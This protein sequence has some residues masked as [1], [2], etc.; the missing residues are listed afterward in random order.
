MKKILYLMIFILTTCVFINKAN[1][2]FDLNFKQNEEVRDA[3]K[4]EDVKAVVSLN[5]TN[6]KRYIE[7]KLGD[8]EESVISKIGNPSR[9]DISEYDFTWYVYNNVKSNFVMVGIKNQKVVALYSNSIDSSDMNGIKLGDSI[10]VTREN[11]KSIEYKKKGNTKFMI[12]S[13]DQFDIFIEDNKYITVFYDLYNESKVTSYQI[14]DKY[15]EESS[16]DIYP[17]YSKELKD[18]FEK[19]TIDLINSVRDREN[20]NRLSFNSKASVSALKH[21]EDMRDENYFDH[22]NKK[23]E[24]PFNRMKKEHI[25]YSLAGENIAAGQINAIYAHEALMN[26][27]GHRKNILGDYKNIGVGV[28]FGGHYKLYYT[29]NFFSE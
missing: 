5:D 4:N 2:N 15:I 21:S 14:I 1:I 26:S 11:H 22:E 19:Q 7:I 13:R 9:K 10:D 28:S 27:I 23:G 12:D 16:K 20:L 25:R 6:I 24:S 29:Q 18:S 8:N 17:K 3:S